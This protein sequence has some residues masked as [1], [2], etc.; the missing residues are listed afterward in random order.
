MSLDRRRFLSVIGATT[1]S[2]LAGCTARSSTKPKTESTTSTET[3]NTPTPSTTKSENTTQPLPSSRK[4]AIVSQADS[5]VSFDQ[6][7]IRQS[8]ESTVYQD[9]YTYDPGEW[10]VLGE[11]FEQ[12]STYKF[13]MAIP[14]GELVFEYTLYPYVTRVEVAIQS[15]SSVERTGITEI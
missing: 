10:L 5:V 1:V 9:T 12:D 11:D 3:R 15:A 7:L 4:L 8:D 14:D 13:E 2:G 6:Q